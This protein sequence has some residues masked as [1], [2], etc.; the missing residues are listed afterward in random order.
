MKKL[1]KVIL[2]V[3]CSALFTLD[4]A[5]ADLTVTVDPSPGFSGWL[6]FMNVFEIPQNGGGFVF[7]S[8]WGTADL[9]ATF[10][11]PV[12]TL[13][14]NT[15]NDP[16]P[17]WYISTGNFSIGNK[18]MDANMFVE[19]GSLPGQTLTFEG[20]VLANTLVGNVN[21]LGNGWTA[22]AFIRDFASDFSSFNQVTAP[23]NAGTFSIS[24]AT[25]NDPTRHVQYG[26]NVNGPDVWATDSELP[27]YGNIQVTAI[28]EPSSL[29]LALTGLLGSVAFGWK[30][31]RV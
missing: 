21:P 26:F 13:S 10:S 19:I 18:T 4:S 3:A 20:L 11:G 22:V 16:N 12:L 14:P 7:G 25:V 9:V 28:P 24:L 17:F 29:G 5:R 31:R 27:G 2:S 8:P 15:I 6:G 30:K 23:L 1:L